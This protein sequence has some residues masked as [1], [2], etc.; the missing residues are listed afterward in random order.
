[1]EISESMSKSALGAGD[2]W[3]FGF[4]F[5]FGFDWFLGNARFWGLP[6]GGFRKRKLLNLQ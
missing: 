1:M 2:I 3:V 6:R 4:Y 5:C